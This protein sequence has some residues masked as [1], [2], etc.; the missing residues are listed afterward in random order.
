M[1]AA[2]TLSVIF[3]SLLAGAAPPKVQRTH[4]RVPVWLKSPEASV[5]PEG[6]E[7]KIGGETARVARVHGPNDDL[8]VLLVWDVTGEITRL[9]EARK[10]IAEAINT[11]PPNSW[12][13]ML[14]AQDG[15]RVAVDPTPDRGP[16]ADAVEA[17]PPGGRAGLLDTIENAA[18]LADDLLARASPRVAVLYVSDSNVYNY[19]EDFANPVINASDSRDLSRAFPE[20][21]VRERVSQLESRL[22]ALTAPV[23][24]YHVDYRSDRLNEAYQTGLMKLAS[25]TGGSA[26]FAKSIAEIRAGIKSMVN[27]IAAH[28]S[29]DV[30][31]GDIKGDE[32]QLL[33]TC[34]DGSPDISYRQRYVVKSLKRR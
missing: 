26:E 14:R 21:L 20:G 30:E 27:L 29:L 34:K 5:S 22:G 28:W 31:V 2:L 3:G 7:A 8:I 23:F 17:L 10:A 18:R 11:L 32:L 4:V 24:I 9:D 25:V 16:I 13:A 6:F 1:K 33:V 19:R 15:L 12:V